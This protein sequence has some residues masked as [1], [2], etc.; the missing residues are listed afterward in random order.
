VI[1][2]ERNL[3]LAEAYNHANRSAGSNQFHQGTLDA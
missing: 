3:G 2:F 1:C